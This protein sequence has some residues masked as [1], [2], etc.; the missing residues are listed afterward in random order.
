M[1]ISLRTFSD[2]GN[3][4]LPAFWEGLHSL[5]GLFAR[6]LFPLRVLGPR[7]FLEFFHKG[8]LA[9]YTI[10]SM[11]TKAWEIQRLRFTGSVNVA[12]WVE[13]LCSSHAFLHF[14]PVF[15]HAIYG[16]FIPGILGLL[17]WM[18]LKPNH[19]IAIAKWLINACRNGL[20]FLELRGS[21]DCIECAPTETNDEFGRND[22]YLRQPEFNRSDF[23]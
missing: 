13:S 2:S 20:H 12:S 11:P 3:E 22:V 1:K 16:A 9:G 7:L 14:F 8:F 15:L 19:R 23:H 5:Y 18:E 10:L 4:F 17:R 6:Y 21:S